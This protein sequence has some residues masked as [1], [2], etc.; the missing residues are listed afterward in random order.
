M[1]RRF[2]SSYRCFA[3]QSNTL[4]TWPL[5]HTLSNRVLNSSNIDKINRSL[6]LKYIKYLV[7]V[8]FDMNILVF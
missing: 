1:I 2:G 7:I 8:L 3:Q 4:T 6:D 5:A